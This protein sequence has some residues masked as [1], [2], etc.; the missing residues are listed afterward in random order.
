[1]TTYTPSQLVNVEFERKPCTNKFCNGGSSI[2]YNNPS[3]P[4]VTDCFHCSGT[5]TEPVEMENPLIEMEVCSS[6]NVKRYEYKRKYRVGVEFEVERKCPKNKYRSHCPC[7]KYK[8][9]CC[10]ECKEP[11][12]D[13]FLPLRLKIEGDN[14]ILM[15]VK[16]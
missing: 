13:K 6:G 16:I 8:Y 2:Q 1:M 11:F 7:D 10:C 4:K 5:G 9:D 14:S 15:V 3:K 12:K